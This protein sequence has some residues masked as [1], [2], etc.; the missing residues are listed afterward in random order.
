MLRRT[1]QEV[2]E[3]WKSDS[4]KPVVSIVC[5]T[6]NHERYIAK[7]IDS[8]LE[9]ETEFPFDVLVGEDCSTDGTRSIVNEYATKY[10]KIVKPLFWNTNVGAAKNWTTLLKTTTGDFIANC[11]GDDYWSNPNKLQMQVDILKK[12]NNFSLCFHNAKVINIAESSTKLF[13]KSPKRIYSTRDVILS[14]WF[15]PTSSI[16]FRRNVLK[17]FPEINKKIIN[18]DLLLLFVSSLQGKLYYID[19]VM[20]V[21]RFGVPNG[22]SDKYK[23]LAKYKNIL[24]YLSYINRITDNKFLIYILL[25]RLYVLLGILKNVVLK[26]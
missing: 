22:L 5:A 16:L 21:Y 19:K 20:S 25:K 24:N 3:K 11:E 18:G 14:K 15:C 7:A 23:V 4:V 6:Y 26:I 8:F 1:E 17:N 12:N 13:R 2:M 9:Q 10:P